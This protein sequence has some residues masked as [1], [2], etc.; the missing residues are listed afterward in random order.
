M[1]ARRI[2]HQTPSAVDGELKSRLLRA[3]DR[4]SSPSAANNPVDSYTDPLSVFFDGRLQPRASQLYD[5]APSVL[6]YE[7]ANFMPLQASNPNDVTAP[8]MRDD[9][10]AFRTYIGS[11]FETIG[12]D[13]AS[14]TPQ[15]VP[16]VSPSLALQVV[17]DSNVS[18]L[19]SELSWVRQRLMKFRAKGYSAELDKALSYLDLVTQ[20]FESWERDRANGDDGKSR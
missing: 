18:N 7:S 16:V 3:A 9:S 15:S 19:V 11:Q 5:S 20:D 2:N 6:H 12:A 4:N 1:L 14:L 10:G 13:L 17:A 8:Q